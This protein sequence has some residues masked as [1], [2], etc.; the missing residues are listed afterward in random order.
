MY[1][2]PCIRDLFIQMCAA[3]ALGVVFISRAPK[4][5]PPDRDFRRPRLE[6]GKP[7]SIHR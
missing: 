3:D 4:D 5:G 6:P 2:L 7:I 1:I